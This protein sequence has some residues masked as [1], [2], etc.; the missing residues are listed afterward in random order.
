MSLLTNEVTRTLADIARLTASL[1]PTDP[2]TVPIFTWKNTDYQA[3]SAVE[4]DQELFGVGGFT[5]DDAL[6][7]TAHTD[8]FSGGDLPKPHQLL[9]YKGNLFR[10][11]VV[12]PSPDGSA[13][14]FVCN[15]PDRGAGG[16]ERLVH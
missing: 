14:V 16:I 3:V 6:T 5:P 7:I 4:I 11:N 10:I 9:T 8:V 2:S 1:S 15:D 12:K 13:I